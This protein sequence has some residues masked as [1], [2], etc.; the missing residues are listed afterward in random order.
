[1]NQ[2]MCRVCTAFMQPKQEP[3]NN[4]AQKASEG[5]QSAGTVPRLPFTGGADLT[6]RAQVPP[7]TGKKVGTLHLYPCGGLANGDGP[8]GT[9]LDC[10]SM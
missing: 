4:F 1:M 10:K 7:K 2:V 5:R 9:G 8:G 3:Q 6:S